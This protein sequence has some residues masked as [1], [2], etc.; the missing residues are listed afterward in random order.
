MSKIFLYASVRS[1]QAWG[2]S[3]RECVIITKERRA[4]SPP[5]SA[6]ALAPRCVSRWWP[7]PRFGAIAT[8]NGLVA[9][10]SVERLADLFNAL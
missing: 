9:D 5:S 4:H 6:S 7:W 10:E 8:E 1:V 2:L 3:R